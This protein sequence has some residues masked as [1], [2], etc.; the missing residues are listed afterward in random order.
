MKA[1]LKTLCK[2][3]LPTVLEALSV[4]TVKG[5]SISVGRDATGKISGVCVN[6]KSAS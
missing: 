2:N 3:F 1:I 5:Y 4:I 6:K